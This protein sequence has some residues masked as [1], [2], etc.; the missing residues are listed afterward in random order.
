M[1]SMLVLIGWT[2]GEGGL[3]A[4]PVIDSRLPSI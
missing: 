2:P 1:H 4:G 3:A